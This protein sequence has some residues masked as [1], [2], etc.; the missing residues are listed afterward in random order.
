MGTACV[1][2]PWIFA[3]RPLRGTKRPVWLERENEDSSGA[4]GAGVGGWGG[5]VGRWGGG[6]EA[7]WRRLDCRRDNYSIGLSREFDM[8]T[9]EFNP[10]VNVRVLFLK[11]V[12]YI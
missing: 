2:T 7:M 3:V 1:K 4:Q 8:G 5:E 12:L 10:Q 9:F 11:L 6:R